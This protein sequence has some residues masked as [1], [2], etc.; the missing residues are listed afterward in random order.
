MLCPKTIKNGKWIASSLEVLAL[1]GSGGEGVDYVV[2]G[3]HMEVQ[4]LVPKIEPDP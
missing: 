2:I 4:P 3:F 1:P